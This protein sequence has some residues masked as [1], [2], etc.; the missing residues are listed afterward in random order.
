L[1]TALEQIATAMANHPKRMSRLRAPP[2]VSSQSKQL[3]APAAQA[4]NPVNTK[5]APT[6]ITIANAAPTPRSP[7][8]IGEAVTEIKPNKD[9]MVKIIKILPNIGMFIYVLNGKYFTT[10]RFY[11]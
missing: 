8:G 9:S 11:F 4:S 7:P 2:D 6:Q 10:A 5:K 1:N 3:R